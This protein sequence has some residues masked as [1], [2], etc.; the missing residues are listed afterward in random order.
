MIN[1][2]AKCLKTYFLFTNSSIYRLMVHNQACKM[3]CE[4]CSYLAVAWCEGS[5]VEHGETGGAVPGGAVVS[6]PACVFCFICGLDS[7]SLQE[8][9]HVPHLSDH[10]AIGQLQVILWVP[11]TTTW[12]NGQTDV[13]CRHVCELYCCIVSEQHKCGVR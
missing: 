6:D 10:R 8:Q 7:P 11:I 2:L 13:W 5:L 3:L 4:Y 1:Q 9:H 12:H